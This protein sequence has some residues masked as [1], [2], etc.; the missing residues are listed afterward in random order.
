MQK[1]VI[2]ALTF[3]IL[4]W[5]VNANAITMTFEGLYQNND[6]A[7]FLEGAYEEAGFIL[8][9]SNPTPYSF[10]T[11]GALNAR[12]G[13]STA[14]ATY[15]YGYM[16]LQNS[17]GAKFSL[18]SLDVAPVS[19]GGNDPYGLNRIVGE[20]YQSTIYGLRVD[21]SIVS[22]VITLPNATSANVLTPVNII[23]FTE[24]TRVE[25][26]SYTLPGIQIDNLVLNTVSSVPEPGSVSLLL[27]GISLLV[28]ARRTLKVL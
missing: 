7:T 17:S 11:A 14:I 22:Q 19:L 21:G 20:V 1:V 27:F 16:T 8:T 18:L 10:G 6:E 28:G 9:A 5:G 12:F 13:G 25:I 15:N 2:S 24:L 26:H 4:S 23:G 3:I